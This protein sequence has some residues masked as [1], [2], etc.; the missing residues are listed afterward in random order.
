MHS[1]YQAAIEEAIRE[2]SALN[3]QM[4]SLKRR[5]ESLDL[6]VEMTQKIMNR[7]GDKPEEPLLPPISIQPSSQP[8]AW[9]VPLAQMPLWQAI[10]SVIPPDAPPFTVAQAIH[11]LAKNG[12][13][14]QSDNR[15]QIIRN[16]IIKKPTAFE[17]VG[18]GMF[19]I[20]QEVN[21]QEAAEA[22]S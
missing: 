18:K 16:A 4:Q 9:R 1:P 5:V 15:V 12:F 10:R 7:E 19:K 6:Y 13:T 17:K 22:A 11:A 8:P 3:D 20:I 21:G 2:R 14:I